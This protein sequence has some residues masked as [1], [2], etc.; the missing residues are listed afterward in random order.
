MS[1]HLMSP[2]ALHPQPSLP[3]VES[4][5]PSSPPPQSLLQQ[6]RPVSQ[7]DKQ[8]SNLHLIFLT[9]NLQSSSMK[10]LSVIGPSES[11]GSKTKRPR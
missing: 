8:R 5:T 10:N 9:F 3:T 1:D 2:R 7:A 4:A 6:C 11:N